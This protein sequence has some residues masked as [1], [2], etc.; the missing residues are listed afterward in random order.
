VDRVDRSAL[1][2]GTPG[3]V[4]FV[5]GKPFSV[6]AFT[7][8]DGRI[9]EIDILADAARVQKLDLSALDD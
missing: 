3:L 7:M 9:V 1:V 5:G 2:N 6:L 4:S 8:K